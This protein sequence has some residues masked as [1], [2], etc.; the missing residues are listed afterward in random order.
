MIRS[1]ASKRF[2]VLFPVVLGIGACT[3]LSH[4]DLLAR[5]REECTQ[6]GFQP[7]TDRYSDCLLKLDAAR[8]QVVRRFQ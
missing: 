1:V 7:G 8:H 2:L 5:D 4:K 3:T 6:F